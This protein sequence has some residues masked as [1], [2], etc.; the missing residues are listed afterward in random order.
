MDSAHHDSANILMFRKNNIY[1]VHKYANICKS[2]LNTNE[3]LQVFAHKPVLDVVK[4]TCL[5][6]YRKSKKG[7]R[8]FNSSTSCSY[9]YQNQSS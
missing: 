8:T 7:H 9:R 1:E 3:S 5:W 4:S 6:C 2:A